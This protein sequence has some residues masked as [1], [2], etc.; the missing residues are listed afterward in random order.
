MGEF[1]WPALTYEEHDW[2]PAQVFAGREAAYDRARPYKSAIPLAVSTRPVQVSSGALSLAAEASA[3]IAR[4]DGETGAVLAPFGA[5]LLRS[6]SA[7]SSQIENLTAS[8]KAVLMAESGDT[9]RVNASLIAANTTAMQAALNLADKLD[10]AA[11]IA[12]QEAILG[13]SQPAIV[14]RFRQEQVWIGGRSTSPHSASFVPPHHS[15]VAEA[16]AD[17]V[18]FLC[19]TDVTPFVLAM[20]AH[21]QFETIHPFPDGNGRTGRALIHAVLRHTA[22]TRTVTVPV[23]AGLLSNTG[24]Y[25]AALDS[26]RAGDLDPIITI[27][28]E[29]AFA[30][31]HNARLLRDELRTL[32]ELW[33]S[34]LGTVRSDSV[35]WRVLAELPTTPVVDAAGLVATYGVSAATANDAIK[36]LVE[37]E[38]LT[39]A[40]G[41]LRFRKWIASDVADALDHFAERSVRRGFA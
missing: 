29:A 24:S 40:N 17:L 36:R 11:I 5:L 6:E 9:S 12:M 18:V 7:A 16:M 28:A 10:E 41:G 31:L 8:A 25:F 27:S 2:N 4:F 21:A 15:L 19:R 23:S 26:Y 39:R 22:V 32:G 34:K 38:V 14:G 35:A 37:C 30:A 20:V 3:E 13:A 1:A 33:R